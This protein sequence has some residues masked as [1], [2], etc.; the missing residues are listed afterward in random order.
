MSRLLLIACSQ[1]KRSDPGKLAAIERYDGPAFRVLRRYVREHNDSR[2]G[3]YVL[4]AE[5]G[6]IHS[7]KPIP[8][9][10]RRMT[11]QRAGQLQ[12]SISRVLKVVLAERP[13]KEI[14]V[15]VSRD[16]MRPLAA[17]L[18]SS[19]SCTRISLLGGGMGQRLSALKAWLQKGPTEH[20]G[21]LQ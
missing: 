17:C 1:R 3:I 2:L 13:W 12:S 19:S 14:G 20:C 18:G 16:Y 7:R 15:C 21:G 11:T 5:Y 10:E 8:Y 9:Y 6:L 4:S